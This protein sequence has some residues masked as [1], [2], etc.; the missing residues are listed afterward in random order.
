M[1]DTIKNF[2]E[3]TLGNYPTM[4]TIESIALTI[5]VVFFVFVAKHKSRATHAR[6]STNLLLCVLLGAMLPD[7]AWIVKII[8]ILF[9]SQSSYQP[10]LFVSRIAWAFIIIQYQALSL[11]IESLVQKPFKLSFRH[12]FFLTI[13]S[14]LVL[15]FLGTAFF[16]FNVYKLSSRKWY[17][18]TMM[19]IVA[20]YML[21]PLML[22]CLLHIFRKLKNKKI[23]RILHKQ[24][25]IL[26]SAVIAPY[27]ISD[28]I[29][30]CPSNLS[31]SWLAQWTA[32]SHAVI[33]I[34]TLLLT[35][36]IFYCA[37]KMMGLRFLN[38]SNHIQSPIQFSFIDNFKDVFEQL[39]NAMSLKELIHI[40]Q[41]LFK[42]AF[43]LPSRS[44]SLHLRPFD[45]K[46]AQEC[47][48]YEH[49]EIEKKIEGIIDSDQSFVS[50]YLKKSKIL[51][52]DELEFNNFYEEKPSTTATLQFLDK[53][54]ADIFLPIFKNHTI[55]GYIIIEQNARPGQFYSNVERNEMTVLASY[56]STILNLMRHRNLDTIIAQEKEMRE[57]LYKKHQEINQYKE[58][59]RSFLRHS[60]QRE[61]GII[62]YKNRQFSFEN[63]AAKQ[64]IGVNPNKQEGDPLVKKIRNLARDVEHYKSAQRCL[65]SNIHGNKLVL[66]AIPNIEQHSIILLVYYPEV[67]DLLTKQID[68]LKDPSEWDYL[69]YLETT[70]SG[71]LINQLIPGSGEKIIEFKISLLKAALHTKATLLQLPREDLKPTVE[72]L[73]HLRLRNNLH[74]L[75]L[76]APEHSMEIAIKMF[77][78]NQIFGIKSEEEPILKKLADK[79]TLF[80]QNIHFLNLETQRHLAELIHFGFYRIFKTEQR[81]P[82]NVNIM[83]ST[84][85]NLNSLVN[86][87]KFSKELLTELRQTQLIMP[88]LITLPEE[89]L[90]ELATGYSEQ[91]LKQ[92]AFKNFLDLTD[93]E[94]RRLANNRPSSLQELK[95]KVQQLLVQKSKKNQ[96]YDE[97]LFDP[98]YTVSDPELVDAAR[99]GKQALKDPAIM[100]MLWNKFKNQNK[101]AAFLGVNRSS[102]NRRCREYNLT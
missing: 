71:R 20:L 6:I 65:A 78:I 39:N 48:I 5:K 74:I 17:E 46:S 88:S 85:Q 60:K 42:D 77:G 35:Y 12:K 38:M 15:Y 31:S 67:S 76:Q 92:Q 32:N 62:Y 53:I 95:T 89:E 61:I 58:S 63:K 1:L 47:N 43:R 41:T 28:F 24:F 25:S 45:T 22:S 51:I 37:R 57:E 26:L 96:I 56:L 52:Y 2:L 16:Q 21:L 84:N 73:H 3:L 44:I 90:N 79:G 8:H 68:M 4:L 82:C 55:I 87:G 66:Q 75:N 36:A 70:S 100:A 94:H 19:R 80:I 13:S 27:L 102:V 9:F 40:T 29:Q 10:V 101:I 93:T 99:L 14:T 30:T 91:T 72:L 11:F 34:S 59:I 86:E 23:P 97:T 54:N 18:F 81:I 64:L 50:S 7:L 98:A 83:C 49:E 69:L 33:S